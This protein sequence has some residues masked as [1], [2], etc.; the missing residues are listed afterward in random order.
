MTWWIYDDGVDVDVDVD[1]NV[2]DEVAKTVWVLVFCC[3]FFRSD[4]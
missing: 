4:R 1:V 3:C 2:D